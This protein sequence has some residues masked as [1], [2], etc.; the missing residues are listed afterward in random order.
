MTSSHITYRKGIEKKNL[1]SHF[2][3]S[4]KLSHLILIFVFVYLQSTSFKVE[5][6]FA[7]NCFP[8]MFFPWIFLAFVTSSRVYHR[9]VILS[10]AQNS[11]EADELS[12][13]LDIVDYYAWFGFVFESILDFFFFFFFLVNTIFYLL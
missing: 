9:G 10:F 5:Q 3:F 1:T 2:Y 8:G 12:V 11:I 4:L 6:S 7:F 13:V